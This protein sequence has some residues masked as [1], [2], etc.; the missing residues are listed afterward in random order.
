MDII[1]NITASLSQLFFLSPKALANLEKYCK[2]VDAVKFKMP[3]KRQRFG[4]LEIELA[5]RVSFIVYADFRSFIKSMNT[6]QLDPSIPQTTPHLKAFP[7]LIQQ[8]NQ[9]L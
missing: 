1:N 5:M 6:S 7:K 9:M 8:L 4:I 2:S 3:E